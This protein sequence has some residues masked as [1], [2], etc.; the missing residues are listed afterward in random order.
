M[1][2]L[3]KVTIVNLYFLWN[4]NLS[5]TGLSK[6]EALNYVQIAVVDWTLILESKKFNAI[7]FSIQLYKF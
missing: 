7:Y 1:G 2:R 5:S 4:S 6:L 3:S